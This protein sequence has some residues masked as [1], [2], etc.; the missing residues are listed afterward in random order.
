M[1]DRPAAPPRGALRFV[2]TGYRLQTR[3]NEALSDRARRRGWTIAALG[4]PGYAAQ[5]QARVRG[6]LLLAP[7]G[8]DPN[9]RADIPGW[10]R[11][12][13]LEQPHGEIDVSL[14]GTRVRARADE[15]GLIDLTIPAELPSGPTQ[16]L[17]HV[18]G[19]PPVPAPVHVAS[20]EATRGVVCDIDDT[21]WITG[22][23]HPL[24]AAWRTFVGNGSTRRPVEGMAAL[25]SRLVE[26]SPN[27]P[28]IYLS[29]GPWNL[30]GPITDFLDRQGFPAGAILLTDWG[31]SPRALFRSGKAHKRGSLEQLAA[32][33]PAVDWVLIGDDGEHDPEIYRDFARAHP[34]QVA[35]IAL[36]TVAP[37]GNLSPETEETIGA[38]PVFRAGDG[39]ALAE[40]LVRSGMLPGHRAEETTSPE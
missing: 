2:A 29:N 24:R 8:T 19:R 11:L 18:E 37:I 22:I 23:R 32:E 21:V 34:Q 16:A 25:L 10:R 36:R 38:I 33:L 40:K 9:A 15:A 6:R 4:Y 13:T 1:S 39:T 27:A 12:L 7:A 20:P 17:L 31:I 26:D 5:G 3:V 28:V 14:G 30:A 35:A